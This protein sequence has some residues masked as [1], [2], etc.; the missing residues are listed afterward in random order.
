MAKNGMDRMM[1]P[2]WVLGSA[3]A[4]ALFFIAV[5]FGSLAFGMPGLLFTPFVAFW[6]GAGAASLVDTRRPTRDAVIIALLVVAL[7]IVY[8]WQVQIRLGVQGGPNL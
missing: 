3:V 8:V 5:R 6:V 7:L 2:G 4:C 1:L